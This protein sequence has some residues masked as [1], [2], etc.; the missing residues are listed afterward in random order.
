MPGPNGEACKGCYFWVHECAN[1]QGVY[2]APCVKAPPCMG[3]QGVE[4]VWVAAEEWCGEYIP[5]P[6][7][8][9]GE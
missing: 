7:K 8:K 6:N 9:A 3:K 1:Q 4:Y 5:H 2:T